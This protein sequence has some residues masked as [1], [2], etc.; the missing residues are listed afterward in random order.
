MEFEHNLQQ[1]DLR[2]LFSRGNMGLKVHSS[3][4]A[5]V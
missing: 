1:K 5:R 2:I 3:H 4:T